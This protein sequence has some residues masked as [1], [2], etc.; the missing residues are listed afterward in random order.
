[1]RDRD[2]IFSFSQIPLP[3]G[4]L[5]VFNGLV[6]SHAANEP[7]ELLRFPNVSAADLFKDDTEALLIEIISE[8]GGA[9]FPAN[10]THYDRTITLDQFNLSL[11]I[12]RPN[13]ADEFRYSVNL[14]YSH[15]FNHLNDPLPLA[16]KIGPFTRLNEARPIVRVSPLRILQHLQLYL[17]QCVATA[18]PFQQSPVII[19]HQAPRL[20]I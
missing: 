5:E 7:G 11:P 8:R 14:A 16:I 17:P 15:G 18:F 13:A 6:P 10:N 1:M 20:V 4:A 2:C 19:G 3:R 12:A 9:N